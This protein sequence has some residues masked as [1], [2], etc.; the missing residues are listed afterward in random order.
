MHAVREYISATSEDL[1]PHVLVKLDVQN[2]FNTIRRDVILT[3]VRERCPDVYPFMYQAYSSPTPLHIGDHTVI[4]ASGV[5]QGDPLGPVAFALAI[6]SV[7]RAI[8][9]PLNVW[10]LDDATIAGP[11]ATVCTDLLA[12]LTTL[13]KAGLRLNDKKCEFTLLGMP[14]DDVHTSAVRM[15]H[16]ALPA[17]TELPLDSVSLLGSPLSDAGLSTAAHTASDIITRMCDRLRQLDSHSA[18]FFLAHYVSAPRLQYLLRSSPMYKAEDVLKN[19][20]EMVRQTLTDVTNV[21][22]SGPAWQQAALPVK[23]G[24]LG[25]RSVEALALPC[26]ISSLYASAQLVTSILPTGIA[27]DPPSALQQAT[28]RL[29]SSIGPYET[30]DGDAV[31]RQRAWDQLVAGHT[32]SLLTES[33]NQ[34]HRARLL[35]ASQ[36]YTGAWLHALPVPNLGLHLDDETVRVA[37]ALRLGAAVCEPHRC[38]SCNFP[39]DRLGHHGLSCQ[40]SAGRFP[41]HANLN[42]VVK[43]AL[44]SAGIPSILEP[45]GLDRGDGK[46]PDGLTLFPFTSGKCLAWDATCVDTFAGSAVV[47]SALEPGTAARAAE[48]R[49]RNRYA[50]LTSRYR[51][52][53]L[54]VET[55]GVLGPAASALLRELG[56]LITTVSGDRRETAWLRQRLAIAIVRGNSAAVL[57]TA[58]PRSTRENRQLV[59]GNSTPLH[60][61]PAGPSVDR[62]TSA[63][64]TTDDPAGLHLVEDAHL[65]AQSGRDTPASRLAK[66]RAMFKEM[67]GRSPRQD[68]A[69]SGPAG[70]RPQRDASPS[71]DPMADPE[72]A[73]YLRPV[74]QHGCEG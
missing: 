44:A 30:P 54:A 35:A 12:L 7:A 21:D 15:I 55:T 68:I 63:R 34:I 31:G 51:F 2:A 20:D 24:G 5:Q 73:R 48:E 8:Q 10:Y 43:R 60:Q 74:R 56:R 41:R 36:P 64:H 62:D 69:N 71:R 58:S 25:V 23:M 52:E 14:S 4:S 9:S 13:P 16:E 19:I 17:S 40:R 3:S 59:R 72:L 49:K 42:D 37:V 45:V 61:D 26:Y 22:I 18:T 47:Q 53:P 6:D 29:Q 66:H 46:R 33:A 67:A 32:H 70:E 39:V 11:L 28:D 65:P 50:S 57:A 27:R 1:A 38:R